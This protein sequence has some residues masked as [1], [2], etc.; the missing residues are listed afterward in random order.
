MATLD[1]NKVT[2]VSTAINATDAIYKEYVDNLSSALPSPT[3]NSGKF[4]SVRSGSPS[5]SQWQSINSTSSSNTDPTYKGYQ[6]FTTAGAQTFYIPPTATQFYIEAIGAGGGGGTPSSTVRSAGGGSG[7]YNAW[8]IRRGEFGDSITLTVTPGTGGAADTAGQNTTVSWIGR[9]PTGSISYTLT[10]NGGTGASGATGGTEGSE[11]SVTLNRLLTTSGLSGASGASIT[12]PNVVLSGSNSQ[13]QV[14]PFQSTGGASGAYNIGSGGNSVTYYYG[15]LYTSSGGN[16]SG[17]AGSNGIPGSY[18]GSYGSGGAGG[19]AISTGINSWYIRTSGFGTSNINVVTFGNNAYLAGGVSGTLTHSTDSVTWT[20]RTSG[21]GSSNITALTS[22][23]GSSTTVSNYVSGGTG[24]LLFGSTDTIFWTLRTTGFGTSTITSLG[25]GNNEFLSIL[26]LDNVTW[27]LRTSGFGTSN[28][29]TVVYGETSF[30]ASGISGTLTSSTDGVSWTLRTSGF[31]T[32]NI[33]SSTYFNSEYLIGGSIEPPSLWTLRTTG[34]TSLFRTVTYGNGVYVAAGGGATSTIVSSTN[35]IEWSIRTSS[36]NNINVSSTYGS[37]YLLGSAQTITESAIISASTNAIVW[38]LRT[39][40]HTNGIKSLTYQN[41]LY[42][43]FSSRGT[44]FTFTDQNTWSGVVDGAIDR[45]D[46]DGKEF[47]RVF[48][49]TFYMSVGDDPGVWVLR[50]TGHGTTS[51][52]SVACAP[53][54]PYVFC[55]GDVTTGGFIRSSTDS[56]TWF[57]RTSRISTYSSN[58][59]AYYNGIFAVSSEFGL[60][61]GSGALVVTSTNS[62]VWTVRTAPLIFTYTAYMLSVGNGFWIGAFNNL[63]YSTDG[64]NWTL[65]TSPNIR[66]NNTSEFKRGVAFGNNVYV[67]VGGSSTATDLS[68]STDSIHW[69]LRTCPKSFLGSSDNA[70]N[71]GNN[72]FLVSAS[73]IATSTNGIHWF[74]RTSATPDSE[75]TNSAKGY[76]NGIFIRGRDVLISKD[77]TLSVSTDSISWQI[78]TSGIQSQIQTLVYGN[79]I[80]VAGGTG[81]SIITS[82]D[83]INWVIR[84]QPIRHNFETSVYDGTNYIMGGDRGS[85]IVSTDSINWSQRTV[86]L[87]AF[88]YNTIFD[89]TYNS[90]DTLYTASTASRIAVSTDNIVWTLRTSSQGTRSLAYATK[91]R[92][93]FANAVYVESSNNGIISTTSPSV[94]KD[95]QPGG[96]LLRASTD[97]I[98]WISRTT[99]PNISSIETLG[100]GGG[101][102]FGS[103][104]NSLIVSTNNIIWQLRTSGIDLSIYSFTFGNNFYLSGTK[105]GVIVSTD[106][107]VWTLRTA[108]SP[109]GF[110]NPVS[111]GNNR[112]I[113]SNLSGLLTSTDTINWTL[114]TTGSVFNSGVITD[115]KY[116]NGVYHAVNAQAQ[117]GN[118]TDGITWIARTTSGFGTSSINTISYGNNIAVIAGESGVLN[119]STG[120]I[121]SSL[122][123][124]GYLS[125]STDTISWTLRTSGDNILNIDALMTS[126]TGTYSLASVENYLSESTIIASTNNIIWQF[127][128]SGFGTSMINAFT[129][130]TFYVAAGQGGAIRTSTDTIVWSFRTS[131]FGVA[132]ITS[133]AY[134]NPYYIAAGVGGRVRTSTDGIVWAIRTGG[135]GTT[136]INSVAFGGSVYVLTGNSGTVSSASS[137]TQSVAGAGGSGTRGGGG[138]GGGYSMETNLAGIG[139]TGGDGYVKITWW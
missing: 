86:P 51:I 5:Y 80:Y 117:Y 81:G 22:N 136:N 95:Y 87:G 72:I 83:N 43:N 91:N 53:N 21:F 123:N 97:N 20:L 18:T 121:L 109:S 129:Y 56:I 104:N 128:T 105:S 71:F 15:N 65:R 69:T 132:S 38:Q 55:G 115:I 98:S 46:H 33:N 127:R 39:A 112:Y 26:T 28:I 106:T 134:G 82:T 84:T 131:G 113:C 93:L 13:V 36:N 114:R 102:S 61:T 135:F 4:L 90:T 118:S 52:Q 76:G 49:N 79:S 48:N 63:T 37:L 73:D 68:S 108:A 9:S 77:N 74:L 41:S 45:Y 12:Y 100:N 3:G 75:S 78:R 34:V 124:G 40:G 111:F 122:G 70:I 85:I 57:A 42:F 16:T 2:G 23:G 139:G 8:L 59:A 7:A 29:S 60:E 96:A 137:I 62:V 116:F 10:S 19:G 27:T 125:A 138:G 58:H 119:T 50:T 103:Q 92:V 6:E 35:S 17:T 25:Y 32:S 107:I 11:T 133:L 101:Y 126:T 64:I 94:L 14:N 88:D 89:V 1:T 47:I 130:G 67:S 30:V 66:G 99:T 54:G 44:A 120:R 24:G 110:Y 31:G